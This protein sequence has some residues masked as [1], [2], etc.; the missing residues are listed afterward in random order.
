[1]QRLAQ[2]DGRTTLHQPPCKDRPLHV[3]FQTPMT[4]PCMSFVALKYAFNCFLSILTML[5]ILT[6]LPKTAS[7]LW[8]NVRKHST[9]NLIS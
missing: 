3:T 6:L 8:W 7:G 5:T 2:N 1:M 4:W 9:I